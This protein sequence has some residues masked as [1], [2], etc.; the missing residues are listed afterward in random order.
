MAALV[1]VNSTRG[2][3]SSPA[4]H[5]QELVG[6]LLVMTPHSHRRVYGVAI[7]SAERVPA[8]NKSE[9]PGKNG[10][11]TRPACNLELQPSALIHM[12]CH[13]QVLTCL[14]KNDGKDERVSTSSVL[15]Y[16]RCQVF[17]EVQNETN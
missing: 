5:Q 12:N 6:Q 10:V 7:P 13:L 1:I 2:R 4:C 9:S 8:A 15:C 11:M 14:G 16:Q 17:V 3:L